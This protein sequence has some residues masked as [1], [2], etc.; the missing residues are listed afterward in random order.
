MTSTPVPMIAA[1][2]AE[3]SFETAPF[4]VA[5]TVAALSSNRDP[6]GHTSYTSTRQGRAAIVTNN[7]QS[8]SGSAGIAASSSTRR[9]HTNMSFGNT[10]NVPPRSIELSATEPPFPVETQMTIT[11]GITPNTSTMHQHTGAAPTYTSTFIEELQ[12][13]AS[14]HSNL[15]PLFSLGKHRASI[16]TTVNELGGIMKRFRALTIAEN[17]LHNNNNDN[18]NILP[19]TR[20]RSHGLLGGGV[21]PA[22]QQVMQTPQEGPQDEG[23]V[24][25]TVG[26]NS[27]TTVSGLGSMGLG[28]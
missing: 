23:G 3:G 4:T 21:S 28:R 8:Q 13:L 6:V 12:T 9:T 24:G 11:A 19:T 22:D 18:T 15:T 10:L 25:R 26:S 20:A 7:N 17:T 5:D 14:T 2:I 16:Q 27:T 1:I